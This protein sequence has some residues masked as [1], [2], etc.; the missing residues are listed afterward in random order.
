[1][2]KLPERRGTR[3]ATS[4]G[5]PHRQLDQTPAKEL[6]AELA[7]RFEALPEVDKG[8]SEVSVPGARALFLQGCP[9]CNRR[10]GFIRGR[11]FAHLH[12]PGDGSF[13]MALAPDDLQC[14]LAQGWGELHPWAPA[15]RVLPNVAMVYAP[16]D[17]GEMELALQIVAASLR[18]AR[19][20]QEP[21]LEG[22]PS[23]RST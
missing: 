5:T 6:Y 20:Q 23:W 8:P 4:P 18:N 16:R 10:Y 19:A 3:P 1:M 14:V 11:E 7:M 9:A 13:H 15:G 21:S 17:A 12:P 22:T 2:L